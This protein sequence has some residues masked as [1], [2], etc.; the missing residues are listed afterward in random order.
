MLCYLN[1]RENWANSIEVFCCQL[2]PMSVWSLVLLPWYVQTWSSGIVAPA[3]KAPFDDA[4]LSLKNNLIQ[5]EWCH[6]PRSLCQ[7]FH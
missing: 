3:T 6:S 7:L 5:M 4:Q 1:L 2:L